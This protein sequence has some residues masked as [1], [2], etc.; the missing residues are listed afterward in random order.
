[1]GVQVAHPIPECVFAH[2]TN[3]SHLCIDVHMSYC[4]SQCLSRAVCCPG[5]T[6]FPASSPSN[7]AL[8]DLRTII[9]PSFYVFCSCSMRCPA[10]GKTG[11]YTAG[12]GSSLGSGVSVSERMGPGGVVSVHGGVVEDLSLLWPPQE[13]N[14]QSPEHRCT[15]VI[16]KI[17]HK[18][19]M[20]TVNPYSLLHL[21]GKL[22]SL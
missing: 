20:L 16:K 3:K 13:T 1:M 7:P 21:I 2:N 6:A 17:Y 22:Q 9:A 15:R 10:L 12:M 11:L 14:L 18:T 19:I 5:L 8:W 4:S